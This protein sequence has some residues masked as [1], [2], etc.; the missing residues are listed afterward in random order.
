MTI[1]EAIFTASRE[2]LSPQAKTVAWL[3]AFRA[4]PPN[5]FLDISC[6]ENGLF[7]NGIRFLSYTL[8]RIPE[9]L[10]SR[11]GEIVHSVARSIAEISIP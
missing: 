8:P 3:T 1:A 5:R 9:L 11:V 4:D 10:S 7:F 6:Q 2:Y